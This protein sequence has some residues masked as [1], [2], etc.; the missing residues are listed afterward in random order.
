M[1]LLQMRRLGFSYLQGEI[2]IGAAGPRGPR[3]LPGPQVG[4]SINVPGL[5]SC[6][7]PYF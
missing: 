6:S 2:G 1:S 3:G 5:A 7:L 4:P